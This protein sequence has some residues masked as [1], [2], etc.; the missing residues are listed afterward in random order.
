[1]EK[2]QLIKEGK[3]FTR[4]NRILEWLIYMLGYTIVFIFVSHLF[5]S[6]YID[7]EHSYIYSFLVVFIVYLL[8]ITIKPI[9]VTLT[10]P[11]TGVTLGLFY[12]FINLFIL[13]LTD[14]ILGSHF[15]LQ[16]FWIALWIAILISIMNFLMEGFIIKPI[17]KRVKKHE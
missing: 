7:M 8:N 11:I 1:V 10:I 3:Q 4:L 2:M 16:N 14:W 12:P 17:V 5:D 9:L 13:K 6:L 15:D